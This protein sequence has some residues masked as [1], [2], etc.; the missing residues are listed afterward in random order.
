MDNLIRVT[1]DKNAVRISNLRWTIST[2]N[3][4]CI[5]SHRLKIDLFDQN[6]EMSY[7]IFTLGTCKSGK[8]EMEAERACTNVLSVIYI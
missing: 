3:I 2:F 8:T 5:R 6:K 4:H 1:K 7:I